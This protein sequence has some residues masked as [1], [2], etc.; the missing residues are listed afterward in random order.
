MK[1]LEYRGEQ[2][3]LKCLPFPLQG[4]DPTIFQY[5]AVLPAGFACSVLALSPKKQLSLLR[6]LPPG[7]VHDSRCEEMQKRLRFSRMLSA[8]QEG[9][10]QVTER[11]SVADQGWLR[12]WDTDSC[13]AAPFH[14]DFPGYTSPRTIENWNILRKDKGYFKGIFSI[15]CEITNK[16]TYNMYGS[17]FYKVF[18]KMRKLC[19][20]CHHTQWVVDDN[21]NKMAQKNLELPPSTIPLSFPRQEADRIWSLGEYTNGHFIVFIIICYVNSCV[22]P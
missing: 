18:A 14:T 5:H 13:L 22:C 21:Y 12:Q 15:A 6:I 8:N 11:A 4:C 2:C 1:S 3:F 9:W 20:H 10:L 7:K 19:K 16:Y 17:S